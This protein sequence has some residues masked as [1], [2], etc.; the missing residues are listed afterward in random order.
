MIAQ[1]EVRLGSCIHKILHSRAGCT[2]IDRENA[3]SAWMRSE[4]RKLGAIAHDLFPGAVRLPPDDAAGLAQRTAAVIAAGGTVAGA[5]FANEAAAC[6]VDFAARASTALRLY[7][8]VPRC[9]DLEQHGRSLEFQTQAGTLQKEWRGHLEDMALRVWIVQ[10]LWPKLRVLPFFISPIRGA[11]V[12][13]EGLHSFF[14]ERGEDLV[15][16][17]SSV[18]TEA[19]AILR[20]I[21]VGGEC[22]SLVEEVPGKI[23]ALERALQNPPPPV[24]GYRCKKC[25]FRTPGADSG[26]VR[27]WGPLAGVSPSM[28]DVGYMYF[29]QDANKRPVADRLAREGRVSMYDIPVDRIKGGH[30]RRQLVQIEGTKTGAEYLD[31]ALTEKLD[32]DYPHHFLDIETIRSVMP[33]HARVKVNQLT[34]FQF[35]SHRRESPAGEL[36]HHG[37]LNTLP[38]D[39]NRDFLASLRAVLGD[40]GTIYVWTHYEEQSFAE[41]LA[42]LIDD[43]DD[44]EDL[45]WLNQLLVGGRIVDLHE[46]CFDH[47]WHPRM[48]GRTSIKV[49]L[50]AIWSVDSPVKRRS[51]FNEFP[52]DID[53]YTFLKAN[54]MVS[55]GVGAMESY[56]RS[57][58]GDSSARHLASEELWKYC[59]VDTLA[60]VYVYDF[61]RWRLGNLK[62]DSPIVVGLDAG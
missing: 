16:T 33:V 10:Q 48:G 44:S 14:E 41:I 47:Y 46:L 45:R 59:A 30:A 50:P 11:S 7:Q 42:E 3:F 25:E 52:A 32:G 6:R 62:P 24:I 61:W 26:F 21:G 49:V 40:T 2:R 20:T 17:D 27:C 31:Q 39:P 23:A 15:L 13:V 28:F 58:Q 57:L 8:V 51:P 18:A 35:S 36:T 43:D 37:W 12:K 53:P 38:E 54:G 56:L 60:M 4:A 29:I 19:S 55:D 34:C 1:H 5:T 22:A 9:V